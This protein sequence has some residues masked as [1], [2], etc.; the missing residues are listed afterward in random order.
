MHLNIRTSTRKN[1]NSS[2]LICIRFYGEELFFERKF[3]NS[4]IRQLVM[5]EINESFNERT[6][7]IRR[8]AYNQGWKDAK[9][10]TRKK[11]EFNSYFCSE[12]V[13]W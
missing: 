8:E 12:Y 2:G 6:R 5:Q 1:D 11:K 3:E 13:G 7:K 9:S 4:A 10:K